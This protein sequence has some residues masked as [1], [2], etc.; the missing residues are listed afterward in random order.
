MYFCTMFAAVKSLRLVSNLECGHVCR[1]HLKKMMWLS[2]YVNGITSPYV[3]LLVALLRRVARDPTI[4]T[5]TSDEIKG[6]ARAISRHKG[7][8]MSCQGCPNCNGP[9]WHFKTESVAA[10]WTMCCKQPTHVCSLNSL[11]VSCQLWYLLLSAGVK[12]SVS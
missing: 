9:N 6:A 10:L 11:H 1:T 8:G 3:A 4:L 12:L 2:D 7:S 5:F